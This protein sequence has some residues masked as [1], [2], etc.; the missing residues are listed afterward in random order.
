MANFGDLIIFLE[1]GVATHIWFVLRYS[2]DFIHILDS[3]YG[4]GLK[5]RDIPHE[6][7]DYDYIYISKEAFQGVD[8]YSKEVLLRSLV[9]YFKYNIRQISR[10]IKINFG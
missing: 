8:L 6:H 4:N 5:R 2:Q 3:S 1:D 10:S 7:K 9:W